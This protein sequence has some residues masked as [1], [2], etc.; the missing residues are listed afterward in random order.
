MEEQLNLIY[1]DIRQ[2]L[3]NSNRVDEIICL[4]ENEK[5]KQ[6]ISE[7]LKTAQADLLLM[8]ELLGDLSNSFDCDWDEIIDEYTERVE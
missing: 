1:E 4:L 2:L 5:V 8:L 3:I 7:M 6:A